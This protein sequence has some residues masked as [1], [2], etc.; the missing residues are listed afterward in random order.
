MIN[1]VYTDIRNAL[2]GLSL[3]ESKEYFSFEEVPDSLS[4]NTYM[5][6]PIEFDESDEGNIGVSQKIIMIGI[7]S[8]FKIMFFTKLPANNILDKMLLTVEKIENIVKAI[9]G[10]T[11]GEDEKDFISFAGATPEVNN[12]SLVYEI[13]FT[14][15]YRISNI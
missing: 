1:N 4:D 14:V 5:I 9:L 7:I 6:S 15:N 12:Q 3:K 11:I 8:K 10:L 2:N 13:N